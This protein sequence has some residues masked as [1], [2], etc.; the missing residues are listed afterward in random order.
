LVAIGMECSTR[1]LEQLRTEVNYGPCCK[2]LS[3]IWEGVLYHADRTPTGAVDDAAGSIRQLV[4][5]WCEGLSSDDFDDFD[6]KVE[7]WS[8]ATSVLKG[9]VYYD[10]A[11][12]NLVRAYH[13][14][15]I[16]YM[17]NAPN[18]SYTD[19]AEHLEPT[20]DMRGMV[21]TI[22]SLGMQAY[23]TVEAN[24]REMHLSTAHRLMDEARNQWPAEKLVRD[25]SK[26]LRD[27][28]GDD[29]D[30]FWRILEDLEP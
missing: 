24:E 7:A 28:C 14:R 19:F 5:R 21:G 10:E 8:C 2:Q 12:R 15:G 18:L 29:D 4:E 25:C 26:W 17:W 16:A 1:L 6:R 23:K 20:S 3:A 13:R 30:S 9:T 22:M 27:E 11:Q